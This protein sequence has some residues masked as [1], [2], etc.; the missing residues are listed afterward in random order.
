LLRDYWRKQVLQLDELL[1]GFIATYKPSGAF[2][3]IDDR[4]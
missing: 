3:L 1:R 4:V 2:E